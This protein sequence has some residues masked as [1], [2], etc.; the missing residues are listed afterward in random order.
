V[1]VD[2]GAGWI[3]ALSLAISVNDVDETPPLM[4]FARSSSPEEIEALDEAFGEESLTAT[5]AAAAL[6]T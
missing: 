4:A 5:L 1:Q 2:D 6:L 3:A